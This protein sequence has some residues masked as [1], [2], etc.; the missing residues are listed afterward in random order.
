MNYSEAE[1]KESLQMMN[2][3]IRELNLDVA[4][5]KP[6]HWSNKK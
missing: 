3:I 2:T 6:Q 1:K 4:K 5:I